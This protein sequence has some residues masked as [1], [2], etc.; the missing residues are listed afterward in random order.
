MITWPIL[1]ALILASAAVY[2]QIKREDKQE[3][4]EKEKEELNQNSSE[5]GLD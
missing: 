2:F 1:L 4:K 3:Q 5:N